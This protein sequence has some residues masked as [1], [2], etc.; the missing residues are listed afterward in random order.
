MAEDLQFDDLDSGQI[1]PGHGDAFDL[2]A[3]ADTKVIAS[4][5]E[6]QMRAC[7]VVLHKHG[8]AALD[9]A[10]DGREL[11]GE[12]FQTAL[13]RQRADVEGAGELRTNGALED[14]GK[15]GDLKEPVHAGESVIR[16]LKR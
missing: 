7:G 4:R 3:V 6:V 10:D 12:F 11:D 1:K 2:H 14:K 8:A 16:G 13:V 9:E 15:A 5:F